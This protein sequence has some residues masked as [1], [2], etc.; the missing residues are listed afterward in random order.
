MSQ[1]RMRR[2]KV[3]INAIA[4]LLLKLKIE[5]NFDGAELLVKT[6]QFFR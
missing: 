5:A 4:K 6:F 1:T 2:A 3:N